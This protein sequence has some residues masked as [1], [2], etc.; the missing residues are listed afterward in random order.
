MWFKQGISLDV[1]NFD[2]ENYASLA[3]KLLLKR[4]LDGYWNKRLCKF[5]VTVHP[6]HARVQSSSCTTYEKCN[7]GRANSEIVYKTDCLYSFWDRQK[8]EFCV[9]YSFVGTFVKTYI[10]QKKMGIV[11]WP[12]EVQKQYVFARQLPHT[13]T[14]I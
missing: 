3:V 11:N 5:R 8:V 4:I 13:K 14:H 2:M 12:I 7:N 6:F 1:S 10:W 9:L